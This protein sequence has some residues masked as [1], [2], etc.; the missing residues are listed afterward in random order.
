[1]LMMITGNKTESNSNHRKQDSLQP[2]DDGQIQDGPQI[3][4]T[5]TFAGEGNILLPS[6]DSPGMHKFRFLI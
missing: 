6:T 4:E 5:G 2:Q 1:M 3:E